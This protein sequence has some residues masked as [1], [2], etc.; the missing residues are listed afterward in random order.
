MKPFI[1]FIDIRIYNHN[2]F[3]FSFIKVCKYS[4]YGIIFSQR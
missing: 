3:N 2:T 4:V 1:V